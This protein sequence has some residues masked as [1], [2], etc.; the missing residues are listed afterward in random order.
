MKVLLT[1]CFGNIGT[2]V[3]DALLA[4]GHEVRCFDLDN[5]INR[6]VAARY[7]K[8]ASGL[9]VVWGDITDKEG[10]AT[11]VEGVDAVIHNA[12]II[13]PMSENNPELS[14]RINVEGTGNIVEAIE[15]SDSCSQ[16]VFPSSISVHGNHLPGEP[17]PRRIT[18]PF[19][20]EDS[21]AGQKID[22]EKMIEVGS[23]DWTIVRIG[24][25]M[26]GDSQMGGELKEGMEMTFKV[27]PQC[28]I[29]WVHPKDV[30]AAMVNALG[31]PEAIGNKFF[32]GGGES[33]RDHWRDF[34]SVA[35]VSMGLGLLPQEAFG[36][37]GY[38]TEW[39]D[40]EQA[41][42]VLQFQQHTLEDYRYEM[43]QRFK[44]VRIGIW[45]IKS[46]VK[47][48]LVNFSPYINK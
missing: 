13:P 18:D 46:L 35:F 38:Y 34:C 30:A 1:G 7:R 10:V 16:L 22:C 41:Q 37:E 3:I 39:M 44:W 43:N 48:Y 47:K 6:K 40:T 25:C 27:D 20:A 14:R 29:E 45:P 31:N 19:N 21:Y 8:L 17:P 33:C 32:L 11:A 24:A 4:K 2:K 5:K 23:F 36:K 9:E 12:A 15:A 42:K 28:R 26:D